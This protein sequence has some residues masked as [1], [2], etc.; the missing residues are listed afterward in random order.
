MFGTAAVL[1]VY[2]YLHTKHVK[3]EKLS[4]TI[5]TP[6]PQLL[7]IA[8][9][10]MAAIPPFIMFSAYNFESD[11]NKHA[12]IAVYV[13]SPLV[14]GLVTIIISAT[15]SKYSESHRTSSERILY[16]LLLGA[17]VSG[18][19]HI[20]TMASTCLTQD[21][22]FKFGRVFIPSLSSVAPGSIDNIHT[23]ALLFLQYDWIVVCVTCAVWVYLLLDSRQVV[24]GVQGFT[25]RVLLIL[26][27]TLLI[28]PGA[29][30]SGAL[31]LREQNLLGRYKETARR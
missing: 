11:F 28:G 5:S 15:D 13:L 16:S 9:I 27:S 12:V 20:Y 2:L 1:P 7:T 23:G 24:I 6:R 14:L 25:T 18:C 29:T 10:L 3:F 21:E 17:L 19:V 8:T 22:S 30:V 31:Y 26:V 4:P